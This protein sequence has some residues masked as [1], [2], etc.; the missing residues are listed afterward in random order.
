[1]LD[2]NKF[3]TRIADLEGLLQTKLRLRGKSLQ[4]R[5]TKAGRLLPKRLHRS[6][7]ILT[8]AQQN[9]A[10]PKLS[11]L[12]DSSLVSNAF[13]DLETHL[14]GIDPADRRKGALL[15]WAGGLVFNL[16]LFFG[17]LMFLLK[18]KEFF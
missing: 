13:S 18:L 4:A 15:G 12:I 8:T 6:G 2:H 16:M 3:N 11:R 9:L 7:K 17:L 5:L 10:H 1:M 14:N